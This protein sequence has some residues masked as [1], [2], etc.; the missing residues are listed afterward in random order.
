MLR[1]QQ[2]RERSKTTS[3]LNM[4]NTFGKSLQMYAF[5]NND[6]CVPYYGNVAGD[7]KYWYQRI[8]VYISEALGNSMDPGH[9]KYKCQSNINNKVSAI[10]YGWNSY[11]G[12]NNNKLRKM[13]HIRRP[14]RVV[15]CSET[16]NDLNLYETIM[17]GT[18]KNKSISFCHNNLSS[19]LLHPGGNVSS[20][21]FARANSS[22]IEKVYP[23]APTTYTWRMANIY[24][25]YW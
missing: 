3:C 7:S 18:N 8:R 24:N 16:I 2:A 19:N 6:F 5:D 14:S 22:F 11:A 20:V 1:S 15:V 23:Y 12:F 25:F 17:S 13:I 9:T 21:T 4:L 10:N